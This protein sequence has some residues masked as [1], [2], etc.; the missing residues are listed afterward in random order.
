MENESD[1]LLDRLFSAVRAD[2]SEACPQEEHFETRLMARIRERRAAHQ[3]WYLLAWRML[4]AY[5]GLVAVIA[6]CSV[7]FD[8]DGSADLFTALTGGQDDVVSI[9]YLAGE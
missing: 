6:V 4:P 1:K 7:T 5:A 3:P 8:P 9:S 2:K